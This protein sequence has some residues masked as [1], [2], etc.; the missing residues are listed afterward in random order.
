MGLPAPHLKYILQIKK[1]YNIKGPVLTFGNQDIYANKEDLVRWSKELN[2]PFNIPENI[3]F[4]QSMAVKKINKEAENYIHAETFFEF[5]N[6][7]KEEYYDID[8]F[9]FDKPVILHDLEKPV[10]E[11]Y[12]NFFEFVLDTGTAEHIFDVRAV[13]ENIIRVTKIG[14]YIL[15]ILPAHNYINH[16]FY[17]FSPTFFYDFYSQNGF[18]I[19]E[20]HIIEIRG[21]IHRFHKYIQER[22]YVGIS[23]KPSNRLLNC[24]L[25]R[26]KC[27]VEKL[28]SPDQYYYSKLSLDPDS[29]ANDFGSGLLEK[30]VFLA[31]RIVPIRF[32]GLFFSLWLFLKRLK[33]RNNYFDLRP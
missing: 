17:Q 18:E 10:G 20:S 31:R 32:H 7:P 1:K 2:L 26:K 21:Y 15:Q 9:N 25:V 14:G 6:I 19:V 33:S 13:M 16:G 29:V 8:K 5:M 28:L 22:D 23:F 11:S 12:H 24:F 30:I 27:Y 3:R 4:S